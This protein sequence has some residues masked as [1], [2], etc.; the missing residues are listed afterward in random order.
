MLVGVEFKGAALHRVVP[1]EERID[2]E[3]GFKFVDAKDA[4]DRWHGRVLVASIDAARKLVIS[5]GDHAI[6]V[7]EQ[8]AYSKFHFIKDQSSRIFLRSSMF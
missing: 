8:F 1:A 4:L 5:E 3:D 2:S 6:F 7:L